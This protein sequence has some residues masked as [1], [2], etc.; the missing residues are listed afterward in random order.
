MILSLHH[1]QLKIYKRNYNCK[2]IRL[3]AKRI[4]YTTISGKESSS[5]SSLSL[6]LFSELSSANGTLSSF[7]MFSEMSSA[8][9]TLLSGRGIVDA[10]ASSTTFLVNS[11]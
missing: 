4:Y 5:S 9:G 3:S 10:I 2:S 8:N 7:A 11:S 6:A 1:N